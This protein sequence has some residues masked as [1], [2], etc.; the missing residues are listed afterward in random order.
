ME[1]SMGERR[2]VTNRLATKYRQATRPEKSQILDDLV[3]L[4][5]WHRD[6]ARPQLRQAGT[7]RLVAPR[8]PRTPVYTA[9]VVSALELCWRAA[10][11]PAGKRLAP[12]LSTDMRCSP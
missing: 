1:L 5:G 11:C 2:A 6:H 7:V 4:T 10:Q 3:E 12:M 8:A 9:E